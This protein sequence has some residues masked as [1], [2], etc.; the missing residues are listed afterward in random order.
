MAAP[1]DVVMAPIVSAPPEESVRAPPGKPSV[2]AGAVPPVVMI[3]PTVSALPARVVEMFTAP[4]I[5]LGIPV[6]STEATLREPSASVRN[7]PPPCV[8]TATAVWPAPKAIGVP[9]VPTL[10]PARAA[11]PVV[12]VTPA[13]A[14]I[15][16]PAVCEI[17]AFAEGAL[18]TMPRPITVRLPVTVRFP[19]TLVTS[20][21]PAVIVAPG[22]VSPAA[23][24]SFNAKDPVPSETV[25]T[26]PTA[27]AAAVSTAP[28]LLVER[29][30]VPAVITPLAFWEIELA[31]AVVASDTVPAPALIG[32]FT[33]ISPLVLR[34]T[35]PLAA[36]APVTAKPPASSRSSAPV[37]SVATPRFVTAFVAV[38][39][40]AGAFAVASE[41]VAPVITPVA[42]CVIALAAPP[43]VVS[44]TFPAPAFTVLFT[45]SAPLVLRVTPPVAA[46]APV[47]VNPPASARFSAP[48]PSVTA[49]RFVTAFVAVFSVAGAFAVASESVTPVI[50]PVAFC[51][52]ALAAPPEVVSETAFAPALIPP[53]PIT[54]AEA[55]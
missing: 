9:G 38:F 25:P 42:F 54:S 50:T 36:T 22:S 33:T 16:P 55:V 3:V 40:V 20:I 14:L 26:A 12:S 51:V 8:V 29:F 39:S 17:V 19:V 34:F 21:P 6:V 30:S 18:S 35:P 31:A 49:P 5:A 1:P 44:E 23:A 37:P 52:I 15:A 4:P 11:V 32:L 24:L 41:S 45:T 53:A 7:A 28:E 46:T 43:E 2:L 10:P 27:F 13:V 48:V 47:T